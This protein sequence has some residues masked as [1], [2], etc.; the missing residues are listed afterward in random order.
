LPDAPG[1]GPLL[2][3]D[4]LNTYDHPDSEPLA[5]SAADAVPRAAELLKA[6]RD[7]GRRVVY[8]NDNHQDWSATRDDLVRIALDGKHPELVEPLLPRDDEGFLVKGRH[9]AF[10]QTQLDFLLRTDG[11][12]EITVVGQ[13]TEQ[14]VLYTVIDARIREFDVTLVPGAC[15]HIDDHLAE[16]AVE[17]VSKNLGVEIA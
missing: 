4:A 11:E 8:V 7:E 5:E 17:M 15:A 12:T 1:D 6:A 16:A 2:V 3:V 14:C 10:W 13:V 9:S